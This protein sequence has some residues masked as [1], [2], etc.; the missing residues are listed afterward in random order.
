MQ[1]DNECAKEN[2]IFTSGVIKPTKA[3]TITP[4]SDPAPFTIEIIEAA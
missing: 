2:S 3:G 4:V 1:K